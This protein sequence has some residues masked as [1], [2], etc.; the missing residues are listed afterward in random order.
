MTLEDWDRTVGPRLQLIEAGAAMAARHARKLPVRSCFESL[1]EN[2]LRLAREA[3]ESSLALIILA[4][5]TYMAK[6]VDA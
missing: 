3:L 2:E 6:P 4:Q 5:N 1:A